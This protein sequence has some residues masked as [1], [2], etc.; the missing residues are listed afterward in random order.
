MLGVGVLWEG[1]RV[2]WGVGCLDRVGG[3]RCSGR[4]E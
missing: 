2:F 3:L 4:G 1:L